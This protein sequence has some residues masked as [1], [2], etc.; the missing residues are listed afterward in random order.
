MDFF[1]Q[2]TTPIIIALGFFDGA[3]IGHRKI[4]SVA[5]SLCDKEEFAVFTFNGNLFK[6]SNGNL[7][8][9]KEKLQL[10][11]TLG[12]KHV[13]VAE[14]TKNLY[15]LSALEF[16]N[17]LVS[18]HNVKGIV[19]GEDF[20]FGKGAL[21]NAQVLK[22]FC[23]A[24]NIKL[25]V[26]SLQKYQNEQ[27]STTVIKEKLACGDIK[28]ANYLL[29]DNFFISGIVQHGRGE[30]TAKTFP[31]AN[32]KIPTDKFKIKSGVYATKVIVDGKEY[33][34]LTNYGNC[35]TFNCD[36]FLVETYI[37][38]FN[39]IIYNKEI[40]IEFLDYLRDIKKFNSTQELKEQI[41]NDMEYFK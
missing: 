32:L 1:E 18:L 5:K 22:E 11:K 19:C 3:H 31:T 30:G 6:N 39:G 23:N 8:T 29:G 33:N 4:F 16:L 40:K 38:N 37:L 24:N 9:L 36:N 2:S 21:G 28:T 14:W 35:P 12:A 25:K 34:G 7:Y 13:V 20:T 27:I 15:D 26:V 10:F 41:K 17:K